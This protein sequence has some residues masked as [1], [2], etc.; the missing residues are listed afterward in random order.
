MDGWSEC[1]LIHHQLKPRHRYIDN[2]DRPD[3]TFYDADFR[4]NQ[5]IRY[6]NDSPLKQD[7]VKSTAKECGYAAVKRGAIKQTNTVKNTV[8][9]RNSACPI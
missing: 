2:E 9:V 3:I 1:L 4:H 8:N 7:T 5:R 6:F